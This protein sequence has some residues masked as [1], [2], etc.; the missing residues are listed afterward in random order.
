MTHLQ[1]CVRTDRTYFPLQH[2]HFGFGF[3]LLVQQCSKADLTIFKMVHPLIVFPL[4]SEH[5]HCLLTHFCFTCS[6]LFVVLQATL[7]Q[8]LYSTSRKKRRHFAVRSRRVLLL[9]RVSHPKLRKPRAFVFWPYR[10]EYLSTREF[11]LAAQS[12]VPHV[13]RPVLHSPIY[14]E[15]R[16]VARR[17][18]SSTSSTQAFSYTGSACARAESRH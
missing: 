9:H 11:A 13:R 4:L 18:S 12:V 8:C 2:L 7:S 14:C 10:P 3:G 17:I 6:S 15:Q 1:E 16:A 5:F